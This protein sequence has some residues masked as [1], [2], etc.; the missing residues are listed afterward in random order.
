M[1]FFRFLLL[2][3]PVTVFLSCSTPPPDPRI[4]D[5][6]ERLSRLVQVPMAFDAAGMPARQKE[7]LKALVQAA[8][9]LHTAYLHQAYSPGIA[10]RDSL[11]KLSDETSKKL[12]RLVV[13]NGG[14]F[15]KMEDFKNFLGT[16]EKLPGAGYFPPDLT[17][18]EF[19]RYVAA[20]PATADAFMSPYTVIRRSGDS[21]VAVPYHV[22][23]AEWIKPSSELLMKASTLT[24]NA[25]LSK[26]LASRAKALMSDDYY[27]SDCDWIDL[28]DHDVDLVFG[29]YE[30]YED[31]LMNIKASYEATIGVR[32][33]EESAKLDA[34][35]SH[36]DELEQ[37]LPHEAKYKRSIKGLA[38]PMVIVT[39]II[40]AGDI[41]T[42]YQPVAAN[43][44]NDP[45][46]QT[47]KGT[48]KTFWKNMMKARVEKIIEPVGREVI[49]SDQIEF[50]TPQGVFNVVLM[51]ELCHALGPQYVHG[52]NDKVPVNQGLKELYSAIEE[53]KADV[54]GLHSIKYFIDHGIM[55][56]EM[57]RVHYVSYL[58][59]LFRTI[60]FGTSEA[61]GKAAITELN[62]L[63]DRQGIRQD[64]VTKKWSVNFEK[65]GPAIS[66]IAKIL[67]EFEA[68]GDYPG[69]EN[70]FRKWSSTPPE[71]SSSLSN[72]SHVPV[73]VE[74]VYSIR[75]E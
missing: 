61:H 35:T 6:D 73:D 7:L 27:E 2:I 55:P 51:H 17:K 48:K 22:E 32:D 56:K 59:S 46:V 63:W 70:F 50:I 43:L 34:Y 16:F 20:H 69:A 23:Y 36:L 42:G 15:D 24:D 4:K 26:F 33:R 10:L 25:S 5:I 75:W 14:P 12:Y 39:D 31:G 66:E 11:A 60:R 67:L 71:I 68:S 54:A 3:V 1:R 13:R 65:I 44:P 21:L 8:E 37:N 52:S 38:S 9:L 72:L 62:F 57:E 18:E 49:A 64:P 28:K 47:T 29:P 30:V 40:R 74:P 53:G 19:E 41:A 45:K 58:A